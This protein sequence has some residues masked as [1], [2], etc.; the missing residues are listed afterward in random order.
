MQRNSRS[1]LF[2]LVRSILQSIL[3]ALM[4]HAGGGC[5]AATGTEFRDVAFGSFLSDNDLS[6]QENDL[7]I[8]PKWA[9]RR[10]QC[11]RRMRLCSPQW[12]IYTCLF[13]LTFFGLGGRQDKSIKQMV[14]K[15]VVGFG[16]R[17]SVYPKM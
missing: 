1:V 6:L 16:A 10:A 14:R 15:N 12:N 5:S 13:C 4:V 17:V 8:L 7:V 11:G 9:E 3:N 2:G